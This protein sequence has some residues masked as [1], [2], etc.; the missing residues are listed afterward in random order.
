M[1]A[2]AS[3]QPACFGELEGIRALCG[4]ISSGLR[5]QQS[6]LQMRDLTLPSEL[7]ELAT[8]VEGAL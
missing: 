6:L 5:N 8:T 3:D 1:T 4:Q 7:L 2:S